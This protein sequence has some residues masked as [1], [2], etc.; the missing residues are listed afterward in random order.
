[1]ISIYYECHL[2]IYIIIMIQNCLTEQMPTNGLLPSYPLFIAIQN[3]INS[4]A[5]K[6][7]IREIRI[8]INS[9]TIPL[10]LVCP[11]SRLRRRTVRPPLPP[12]RTRYGRVQGK[13]QHIK[14]ITILHRSYQR[15]FG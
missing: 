11:A 14:Q 9:V 13:S 3:I 7:S 10:H 5:N 15:I 4:I 8:D 2:F 1:M 6:K 12:R